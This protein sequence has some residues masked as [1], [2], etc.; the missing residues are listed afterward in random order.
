MFGN[1]LSS[2]TRN[3]IN[4]SP[5]LTLD[6]RT[7][8]I[9]R[10]RSGDLQARETL[11]LSFAPLAAKLSSYRELPYLLSPDDL[12]QEAMIGVTK[13]IE[14][15]DSN[16]S[17]G[18][19]WFIYTAINWYLN[20]VTAE[21]GL[22]NDQFDEGEILD[23]YFENEIRS[24]ENTDE[25]KYLLSTLDE[26]S[27]EVLILRFGLFGFNQMSNKEVAAFFGHNERWIT[28]IRANALKKLRE[29][30]GNESEK[31]RKLTDLSVL[32]EKVTN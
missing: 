8:L 20:D 7:E 32:K 13:A 26:K 6:Q 19:Y 11:I 24:L 2:K 22:E 29:N 15:L 3:I 30:F 31:G 9:D 1:N 25:V 28:Q 27:Q 10:M 21:Y 18:A 4:N 12:W 23:T 14:K 5:S 16:R 17:R